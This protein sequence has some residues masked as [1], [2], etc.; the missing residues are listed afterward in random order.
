MCQVLSVSVL[1]ET[2][3]K[4]SLVGIPIILAITVRNFADHEPGIIGVLLVK[5]PT[6][7]RR[8]RK[9]FNRVQSCLPGSS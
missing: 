5:E 4:Y 8:I 2:V 3:G 9:F 6:V 1:D 7:S